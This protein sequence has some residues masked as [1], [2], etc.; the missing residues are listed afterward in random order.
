MSEGNQLEYRGVVE[1]AI[2]GRS[3]FGTGPNARSGGATV[4][5]EQSPGTTLS[6]DGRQ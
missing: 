6:C 4:R 3:R 2:F 5:L 1:R